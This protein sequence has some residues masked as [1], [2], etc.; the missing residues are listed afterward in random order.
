MTEDYRQQLH[1]NSGQEYGEGF[2]LLEESENWTDDDVLYE[3][4]IWG[5][6][7]GYARV[8]REFSHS[9]HQPGMRSRG[10]FSEDD[11]SANVEGGTED[12][13]LFGDLYLERAN[14]MDEA[15]IINNGDPE[16][17]ETGESYQLFAGDQYVGEAVMAGERQLTDLWL[18]DEEY[19][20]E[21]DVVEASE[22]GPGQIRF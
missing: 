8:T 11:L 1:Q 3:L 22:N 4:N 13:N 15:P 12:G 5:E 9:M 7:V 21:V 14:N 19:T 20:G 10:S 17:T 16:I 2:Q 18:D 6:T